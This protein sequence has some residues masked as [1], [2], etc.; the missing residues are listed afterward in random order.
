MC[1]SY[2]SE[3]VLQPGHVDHEYI[4]I[5]IEAVIPQLFQKF[6][7]SD[8]FSAVHKEIIQDAEFVPGEF[9][10]PATVPDD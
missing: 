6:F 3:L 7:F 8:N 4:F 10:L 9:C 2:L 1:D 5:Q